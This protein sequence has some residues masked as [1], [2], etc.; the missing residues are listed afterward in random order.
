MQYSTCA[1][2]NG[3]RIKG[4]FIIGAVLTDPP[5]AFD[6]IP[7]DLFIVKL[8]AYRLNSDSLYIYSYLKSHKQCVQISNE[9]SEFDTI[10]PGV[11]QGSIFGPILIFFSTTFSFL[12]Q[13]HQFMIL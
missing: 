9:Q 12:F 6:C 10:I 1:D 3:G 11:P 2:K 5:K 13:Q 8:S 4:N 7:Q